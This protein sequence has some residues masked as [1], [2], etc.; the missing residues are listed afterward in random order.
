MASYLSKVAN[1]N[2]PHL[3]FSPPLGD[4]RLSFAK[5]FSIR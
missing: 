2:L 3:Y 4:T 5:I 1:F